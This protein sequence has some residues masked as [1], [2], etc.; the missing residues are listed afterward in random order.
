MENQTNQNPIPEPTPPMVSPVELPKPKNNY[1]LV[2]FLSVLLIFT[3]LIASFFYFQVQKLSKE[4]SKYQTQTTPTP[5]A[6]QAPNGDLA[7]W[8]TY[9]DSLYEYSIKYPSNMVLEQITNDPF[10]SSYV[11]F[12]NGN[13][14]FSVRAREG[15]V[16]DETDQIRAQTEG[17]V[18]TELIRNETLQIGGVTA[19]FL[20]YTFEGKNN[21]RST[22]IIP[23]GKNVIVINAQSDIFD[24]ILSTFQFTN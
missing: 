8:K 4:L 3:I 15:S 13:D 23:S 24:Q 12:K 16:Q 6:S 20:E 11:N 17:H 19:T 5:T 10:Y 2:I 14:F 18:V 9:V 21:N 1:I 22:L 7:N